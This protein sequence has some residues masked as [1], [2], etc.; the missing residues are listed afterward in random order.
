MREIGN[1][2]YMAKANRRTPP[3]EQ[4]IEVFIGPWLNA[5]GVQPTALATELEINEGYLSQ[6][7]SRKK[8]NPSFSLVAR[9]ADALGI[10]IDQLR[11]MP[12]DQEI[13]KTIRL[14]DANVLNRIRRTKGSK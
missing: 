9:I 6:L 3:E 14:L 4:I 8:R 1:H 5:L 12:P 7:I 13:I 11:K 10:T 2:G